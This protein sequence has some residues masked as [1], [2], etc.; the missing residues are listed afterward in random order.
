[1]VESVNSK[2]ENIKK[3]AIDTVFAFS[4]L[5]PA[6]ISAYKE[7]F[8]EALGDSRYHKSKPIRDA[9]IEALNGLRELP[10]AKQQRIE[11]GGDKK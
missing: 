6:S 9:T 10:P 11:G 7:Q 1:M 3:T 2:D 4:Q 5:L 8:Q